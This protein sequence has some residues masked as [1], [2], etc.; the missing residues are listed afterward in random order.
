MKSSNNGFN[1]RLNLHAT[2]TAPMVNAKVAL[3]KIDLPKRKDQKKN[4]K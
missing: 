1:L 2:L 4:E 3:T